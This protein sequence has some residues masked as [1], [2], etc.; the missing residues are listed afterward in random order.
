MSNTKKYLDLNGLRTFKGLLDENFQ[1]T[2]SDLSTIR[3][4]SSNAV[5]Y[6][7]QNLTTAQ[8]QQARE[9]INA[10][11][12]E[13]DVA[14]INNLE[15]PLNV[16]DSEYETIKI[17]VGTDI[18]GLVTSNLTINAYYDGSTTVSN[19]TTTNQY[20]IATIQIPLGTVY[21]L[22]FPTLIGTETIENI[23]N[24][25]LLTWRF[26]EVK[27][28]NRKEHVTIH[29][30]EKENGV[31]SN[32][33]D[34]LVNIT[35]D[36]ATTT[37]HTDSDGLVEV[38]VIYGKSY[39]VALA[40]RYYYYIFGGIYSYTYT[41]TQISREIEYLYREYQFGLYY[42]DEDG[43]EYT[44]EQ[45]TS[46]IEQGSKYPS[47]A[48]YIVVRTEALQEANSCFG[49]N[50]SDMSTRS[51]SS[52]QW[53]AS[54]TQFNSIALNGYGVSNED[55]YNGLSASL[56]IQSEGDERNINTPAV[57]GCLKFQITLGEDIHQGFLGGIGQWQILW[58]NRYIVDDMITA[59]RPNSV[60]NPL[61]GYTT[62]KWSSAQAN[63]SSAY[64]WAAAGNGSKSNSYAVVPFF[65]F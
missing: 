36:G 52:L 8:Q 22:E 18:S 25:A 1:S 16:V 9:N 45:F 53:A 27:Y 29:V 10:D 44:S 48:L 32:S 26:I 62:S 17:F 31:T 30:Q 51:F 14:Y 63:A 56:K 47:D 43:I 54:N 34:I 20:G 15:V 49:I 2:I 40:K 23:Q 11:I 33:E 12:D 59:V 5:Q 19:T 64:Y 24:T 55:F 7:S 61:S 42:V 57:D 46:L 65:A 6:A 21:Q 13:V 28:Q 58:E 35:I 3:T 37:Y 50:I 41:A 60:V 38:D 39:T 4:N